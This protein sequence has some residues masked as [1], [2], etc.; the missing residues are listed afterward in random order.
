MKTIEERA[1]GFGRRVVSS[2]LYGDSAESWAAQ[3]F[4]ESHT[5]G[6]CEMLNAVL[7]FLRSEGKSKRLRNGEDA[8]KLIE[9]EFRGKK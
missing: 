8:A 7:T 1:K 5:V 3:V 9:Q 4:I 6:Q 2:S